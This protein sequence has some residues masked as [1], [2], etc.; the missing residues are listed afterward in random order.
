[1]IE[2]TD[3]FGDYTEYVKNVIDISYGFFIL[4]INFM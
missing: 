1:M 2:N 3:I 4:Y